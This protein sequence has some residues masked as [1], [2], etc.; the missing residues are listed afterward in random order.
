MELRRAA[1]AARVEDYDAALSALNHLRPTLEAK[2]LARHRRR[3]GNSC[4]MLAG[5]T[6][7]RWIVGLHVSRVL[8]RIL[9]IQTGLAP[10]DHREE[11]TADG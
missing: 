11:G 9:R 6:N 4:Y 8:Q 5:N 2:W 7:S 1:H 10:P 3:I